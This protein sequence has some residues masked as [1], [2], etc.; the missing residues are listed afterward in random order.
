MRLLNGLV[1]NCRRKHLSQKQGHWG[2]PQNT[3]NQQRGVPKEGQCH[4]LTG[5]FAWALHFQ[6]LSR[7]L[8]AMDFPASAPVT[9]SIM[10]N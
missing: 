5:A 1:R 8:E 7:A 9:L 6:P 2:Q 10:P 3:I 4:S